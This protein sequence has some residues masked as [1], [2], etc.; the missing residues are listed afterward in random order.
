MKNKFIKNFN[1]Q[2]SEFR[3][4]DTVFKNAQSIKIKTLKT[5]S[6][7]SKVSRIINLRN[8]NAN[9]LNDATVILP[10]LVHVIRHPKY[11]D[12]LIDS[13]FDASFKDSSGG[14]FKGLMKSFYFRKR[15][16]QEKN[17]DGV[18]KQIKEELI[19]I[20]GVFFT[21]FHEHAAGVPALP[22][23]IPYIF[24]GGEQEINYF[25]F[26][27]SDFFKNKVDLQKLDFSSGQKMPIL[28]N[29]IDVFRDG[30]FWAFSTP[31]HTKGHVSYL[32]NGDEVQTLITGDACIS[33]KGFELETETGKNSI[34]LEEGRESFLKII[35]FTKK[36]PNIEKIFGHETSKFII[37]YR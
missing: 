4:W 35:E 7:I 18:E 19:N 15:Y 33:K 31:G 17:S 16:I 6:I 32:I 13:G 22:D 23:N 34:N 25:P 37:E 9:Q 14:T 10:V 8:I 5:G 27:Y 28:G 11:G 24:G 26:I 1:V 29:C 2:K 3:D 36:Y 30:S 12:Y 20:K 21:H